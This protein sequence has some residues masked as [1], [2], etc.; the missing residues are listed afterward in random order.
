MQPPPAH[1]RDRC[2]EEEAQYVLQIHGEIGGGSAARRRRRLE[3]S[4]CRASIQLVVWCT[5]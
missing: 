4:S 2:I 1:D 5:R 3:L